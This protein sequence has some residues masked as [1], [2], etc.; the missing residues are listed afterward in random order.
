VPAILPRGPHSAGIS[1]RDRILKASRTTLARQG[2]DKTTTLEIARAAG[3]GEALLLK[4][5]ADK[6]ALLAA[7]FD[8][9]W[10]GIARRLES[11][12][13]QAAT[14]AE[15]VGL[16]AHTM[17]EALEHDSEL[18]LLFLLEGHRLRGHRASFAVSNG[19]LQFVKS[20]RELLAQLQAEGEFHAGLRDE[21][22]HSGL[23]G[24]MEGPRDRF[25]AA[26]SPDDLPRMLCLIVQSIVPA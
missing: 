25:L 5:F 7:V 8:D 23:V 20:S 2:F 9:G 24:M 1:I 10:N 21:A 3:T 12:L 13:A 14:T 16:L 26:Y 19:F 22:V 18:K 17:L 6:Q 11:K 15:K 4:Q